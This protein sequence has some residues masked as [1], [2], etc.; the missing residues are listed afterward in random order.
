MADGRMWSM[1]RLVPY[2]E[3]SSGNKSDES[4]NLQTNMPGVKRSDRIVRSPKWHGDYV[5][6]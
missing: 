4:S 6:K 3:Q 1:D 5:M 2:S